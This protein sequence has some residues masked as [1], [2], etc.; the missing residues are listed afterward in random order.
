MATGTK[1]D[2]RWTWWTRC[3]ISPFVLDLES[4]MQ[5]VYSSAAI[6]YSTM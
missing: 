4:S 5:G 6:R 2:E 1:F 3:H